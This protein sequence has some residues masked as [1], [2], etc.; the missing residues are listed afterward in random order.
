MLKIRIPS[1]N[2]I[3]GTIVAALIVYMTGSVNI[4][5]VSATSY[6]RTVSIIMMVVLIYPFISV[7]AKEEYNKP[8]VVC[9]VVLALYWVFNYLHYE[10]AIYNLLLRFLWIILFFAASIWFREYKHI[11]IENYI[12]RI[13][14][15]LSVITL[16]LWVLLYIFKLKLPYS[17]ITNRTISYYNYYN[18]FFV[19]PVYSM[20]LAGISTYRVQSIFWEPGVYGVLLNY[21]LYHYV[22][23]EK[24]KKL[25]PMV[26]LI[27]CTVLTFSTTGIIV[28][29]CLLGYYFLSDEKLKRIK[30]LLAIP[31]VILVIY[32][33]I[34]IWMS[35]RAASNYSMMSYSLR[36]SDLLLG[37]KLFFNNFF[38][39]VGY[40][41]SQVFEEFQGFGRG[42]SN[43]LIT[44]CYSMGIV[45]LTLFLYPFFRNLKRYIGKEKIKQ[46]IYIL[47][48]LIINMTEPIYTTP[49]VLWMVSSEYTLRVKTRSPS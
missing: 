32:G 9:T 47:L 40:N 7:V 39:G 38:V 34:S 21:A 27:V 3:L 13:V 19:S 41:N 26:I 43:G 10:G 15:I 6:A 33:V 23:R 44:L 35:K 20:N 37:L 14:V 1:F 24:K 4:S 46:I 18:L 12:Y 30:I 11:D 16:V 49:L 2:K 45:G 17:I 28:A 29:M 42:N 31:V 5:I 36:M 48:F 8:I 25:L 22:T